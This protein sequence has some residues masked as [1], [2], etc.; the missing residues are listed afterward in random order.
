MNKQEILK[1]Y[2]DH[3]LK[4]YARSDAV[5][6]SG[7]GSVLYDVEGKEYV[8]FSGGI[9]VNTFGVADAE[10]ME[11]VN[12]QWNKL[13]HISNLYYTV[14]QGELAELLCQ[15]SGM[16]K[17][18]FCNSGTEANECAI[19]C[20]RKYSF[21]KYGAGRHEIITLKDS[22]HGRTMG[23]LSATGQDDMHKFFMPFLDGFVYSEKTVEDFDSK[24]SEKTCAVLIELIQGE[25]GVKALDKAFVEHIAKVCGQKDILLMIDEV[26][27]GN[28]RTGSM[29]AYQQFGLAPDVVTTAKGLGGG[30]P[31][32]AVLFGQKTESTLSYGTH[33]AT[34]GANP[35]CCAA[36]LSVVKRLTDGLFEIVKVKSKKIT[37]SLKGCSK[38]KAVSG[39]GL[40]LGVSVDGDAKEIAKECLGKG[41]VI[42]TAKDKL[43]IVPALNISLDELDKGLTIL[44]E[45]LK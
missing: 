7:K 15:K 24:V 26:Q 40:M 1:Q 4:N 42:L 38:V 36:A 16:K 41:L 45:T 34:F 39:M 14:P 12:E 18:F 6:V 23:S 22:F 35:V 5:F 11:A 8:D 29:Y 19:K 37:E 20:A 13:Q 28:G 30:L 43:R 25:G 9:A 2:D 10:V 33:G 17:V 21:D 3:V 27:T 32:G 44:K 31:I